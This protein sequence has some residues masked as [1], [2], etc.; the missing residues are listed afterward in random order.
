MNRI[1]LSALK[2]VVRYRKVTVRLRKNN[3]SVVIVV[4]CCV[5]NYS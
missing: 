1:M 5:Y 2:Q 4:V 3:C